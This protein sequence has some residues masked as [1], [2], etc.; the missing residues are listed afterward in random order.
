MP[1]PIAVTLH[2]SAAEAGSGQA[3]ASDLG[4]LRNACE[5]VLEVL[6]GTGSLVVTLETAPSSSGPWR[7]QGAFP[8]F[9]AP[10]RA[11][12][13]FAATG[14]FVRAAWTIVTGPWQFDLRGLGHVIY[15]T[16]QDLAG[17]SLTTKALEN[18]SQD[19]KARACIAA[20]DEAD[21]YLASRY[22]LPLLQ[23]PSDFRRKVGHVAG[24]EVLKQKGFQ[25]QGSDEVVLLERD[26]A[27]KWLVRV[28]SGSV[29][30]PGIVDST[31][32]KRGSAPRIASYP[33]RGWRE[34]TSE[35]D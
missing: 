31:P 23:W 10:G 4:E 2:A 25:P 11:E 12:L 17:S 33:S 8:A 1:N 34:E 3:A 15:V 29:S 5:L 18:V 20:S 9:T 21:G 14:R 30:P 13:A 19:V 22:T 27:V 35:D 32:L 28:S 26:N 7:S 6:S 24:Y 16:P